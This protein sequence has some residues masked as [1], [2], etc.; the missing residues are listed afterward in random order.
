[1]KLPLNPLEPSSSRTDISS[2]P[3]STQTCES[4]KEEGVK[5]VVTKF[6]QIMCESD[7][8]GLI[9]CMCDK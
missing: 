7:G 3:S 2:I 4:G 5:V 8:G 1:M 6:C 9:C